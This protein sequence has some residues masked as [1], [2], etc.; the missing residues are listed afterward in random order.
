MDGI[1]NYL[2]HRHDN[3]QKNGACEPLEEPDAPAL[4]S[5]IL[6][7]LERHPVHWRLNRSAAKALEACAHVIQDT[8]NAARLVFL[9]IGFGNLKEEST[10]RGDS[11]AL[12]T[13]GM[14]MKSGSI[15]EALMI[16]VNS[17]QER[18]I[19]LPELLRPTLR[20]FASNEHPAIRALILQRL[21]YLQR[22]NPE[23]G[24]ELF[25]RAM[26]DA[27]GLW[28]SAERCLYY[29]YHDHF[30]KVAPLLERIRHKGSR[31]D[32][33]TWGRISALSALAG[34][35]D[36]T[37]LLGEL[38][39]LDISEAWQ[40]AASVWTHPENIK[41]HREQCLTSI[42]EG[43]KADSP[44]AAAVARR[45]ANIFRDNTP[46]ITI[47]I[48]LIQLCFC[49]LKNDSED[50]HHRLFGFDE[51]LNATSQRDPELALAATEI[52]MDYVSPTKPYV[53][54]H[55]KR[56]AQLMTRLFAE[57]EEREESDRGAML[58]RVVSL[59][60]T[61]LS[62]GVNSIND[63]LKAAERQ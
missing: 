21:P 59:Q 32:M 28:E 35:I 4:A 46:P 11:V 7:E 15:A 47:P 22:L 37:N 17:L 16:L 23:L 5:Q 36:S 34:H 19:E 9:A 44:H 51:W 20:R 3:L 38:N 39:T 27:A 10:I 30:E 54:D 63:W 62:L 41:Q 42:E 29:A 33:E 56:F 31:D 60:D 13:T 24:W 25:N 48:K 50:M 12:L 2:A 53:Y 52:Y 8:Q 18:G 40:G 6:E 61:L 26:Q 55:E 58:K 1:V 49:V 43:L 57:A 14:N 45:V